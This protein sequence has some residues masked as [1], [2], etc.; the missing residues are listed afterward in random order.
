MALLIGQVSVVGD[1]LLDFGLDSLAQ[2]SLGPLTEDRGQRV[3]GR[4]GLVPA[5]GW[6]R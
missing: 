4:G 1:P 3:V 2:Q 6:K 5:G